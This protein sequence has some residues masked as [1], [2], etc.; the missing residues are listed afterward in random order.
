MS[1]PATRV[2]DRDVDATVAVTSAEMR[3]SERLLPAPTKPLPDPM[4]LAVDTPSPNS[5]RRSTSDTP[6]APTIFWDAAGNVDD[7]RSIRSCWLPLP[8]ERSMLS[9]PIQC[10][11]VPLRP[12]PPSV[13]AVV[14]VA[15][16]V[17]W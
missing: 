16:V 2:V 1:E 7:V 12:A 9:V 5:G 17:S 14:P 10:W 3:T 8:A 6:P 4:A 11:A 15:L 13:T